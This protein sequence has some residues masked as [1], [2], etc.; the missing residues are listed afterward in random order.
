MKYEPTTLLHL[1]EIGFRDNKTG[2]LS[3][4]KR[5]GK[6]IETDPENFQ[7]KVRYFALGLHELGV[8]KGDRVT[9]HSENSTEWLICDQAI[10]SLGAINV[11]IYTTQPGEQ[12]KFILEN[13]EAKA[14][15]VSNDELFKE[16]KPL[17]KAVTNVVAVITLRES[18]HKKLKHMDE[19][20]ELGRKK[21][22]AE[23][24]LYEQ[25]RSQVKP[26]D[27]ATFIYTSGTTGMP[28]GVMLTHNNV[29]SNVQASLER[30]PF[31]I[32]ANRGHKMLSYLPLSHVF[33][34]MVTYMYLKMGYPVYYIEDVE[35]IREDFQTIKPLFFA[36]VPRLLEK[37]YMGIKSRGQDMSGIKKNLYY[38]AV[39]RADRYDVDNPP[40]GI[41]AIRHKIADMLVYSKIRSL[42]GGNLVGMISGGA[43]LSPNI[44]RFINGIGVYCGQGYGL[45][46]TSP[47][48]TVSEP[49]NLRIGSS[50]QPIAD[51]QVKI[52]EDGEILVKGPNVMQGYFRNKEKTDEAFNDDGWLMTGDIGKI[53]DDGYLY[54]TDRK[55]SV[56][57]L[58]TGKYVSPQPIENKLNDSPFIEQ[59]V[60]V[61]YK[62][63]FCSAL[64]V[65]NY[66]NVRKRLKRDGIKLDKDQW[67]EHKEVRN[68]IQK[69]VDRV[70]RY[71]SHWETVK[72]FVLLEK[73]FTIEDE[74]LTPTLKIKRS[75]IN[76][77]YQEEIDSMYEEEEEPQVNAKQ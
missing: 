23:P 53:D 24:D 64:I 17:I 7:R 61:G 30:V 13:S 36:T 44:M 40:G 38:W 57:K 65:P 60:V 71:L 34:R 42:F 66:E 14:H 49:A 75:V 59:S 39:H 72:K 70:N 11:P 63:K 56:F 68:L 33:E 21:D 58:S 15:I 54:V 41:D 76:Q 10:L 48:V 2:V 69:E 47:V 19:V 74:E 45:S 6:W 73:Q 32:E 31:D 55:K 5:D 22:E 9:L 3:A 62:H 43:S 67:I 28:K 25:L 27:L 12:I 20:L 51:V 50:G 16:T 77:K 37:I 29:A 26:D 35:E 52:A 1:V 4:T 18:S 46:E 8:E